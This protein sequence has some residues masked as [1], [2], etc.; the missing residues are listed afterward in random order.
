MT[1]ETGRVTEQRR[2][3]ILLLRDDRHGGGKHKTV[4]IINIVIIIGATAVVFCSRSRWDADD[5]NKYCAAV[6]TDTP[7]RNCTRGGRAN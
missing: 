3:E 4:T 2:F 5:G 6:Y 7:V 1:R